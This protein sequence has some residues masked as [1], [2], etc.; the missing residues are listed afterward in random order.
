MGAPAARPARPRGATRIGTLCSWASYTFQ[1]SQLY[2]ASRLLFI[3]GPRLRGTHPIDPDHEGTVIG[4]SAAR[5]AK[6]R[7]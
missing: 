4:R 5:R 2:L 1:R 3:W 7:S 6:P